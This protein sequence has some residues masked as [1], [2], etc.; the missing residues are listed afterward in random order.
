MLS[1]NSFTP[2]HPSLPSSSNSQYAVAPSSSTQQHQQ[3]HQ[4]RDSA[5]GISNASKITAAARANADDEKGDTYIAGA[6]ETSPVSSSSAFAS[7]PSPFMPMQSVTSASSGNAIPGSSNAGMP[8]AMAPLPRA[9]MLQTMHSNSVAFTAA[10]AGY[11]KGANN[12]PAAIAANNA[13]ID[14]NGSSRFNIATDAAIAAAAAAASAA[15][16]TN[17]TSNSSPLVAPRPVSAHQMNPPSWLLAA[18]LPLDILL[19]LAG[20]S[21]KQKIINDVF[22]TPEERHE[23]PQLTPVSYIED[24]RMRLLVPSHGL[25]S[26]DPSADLALFADPQAAD[27]RPEWAA[28]DEIET[29][30]VCSSNTRQPSPTPTVISEHNGDD[31][32]FSTIDIT[33]PIC[34]AITDCSV[35][36]NGSTDAGKCSSTTLS[37]PLSAHVAQSKTQYS[38]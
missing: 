23:S 29:I 9:S 3:Q 38:W 4:R 8:S 11:N 6:E 22:F 30:S 26:L 19:G 15:T 18:T 2:P 36:S 5:V 27:T 24:T 28:A 34:G 12:Q 17:T 37:S 35:D 14:A 7:A 20:T 13:F 32:L 16:A 10:A 31:D 1:T 21:Y 33:T 25:E